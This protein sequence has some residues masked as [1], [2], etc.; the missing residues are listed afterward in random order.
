MVNPT[1]IAGSAQEEQVAVVTRSRKGGDMGV[2]EGGGGGGRRV[3]HR[4]FRSGDKRFTARPP[5]RCAI[6]Q[7]TSFTYHSGVWVDPLLFSLTE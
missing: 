3:E 4:V 2:G 6:E 1:D 7:K 5:R